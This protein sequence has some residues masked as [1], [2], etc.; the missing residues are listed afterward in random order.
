LCVRQVQRRIDLIQDVHGRRLE[1]K[2]SHDEGQ[3]DK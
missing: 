2:E 1:L 3:C